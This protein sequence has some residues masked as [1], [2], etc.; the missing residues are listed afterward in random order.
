[1]GLIM[2]FVLLIHGFLK[3]YDSKNNY[4]NWGETESC[5]LKFLDYSLTDNHD[6]VKTF[7]KSF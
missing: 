5:F 1:M 4:S 2:K 7:A 6:S 3:K